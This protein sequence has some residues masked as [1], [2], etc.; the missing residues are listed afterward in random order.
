MSDTTN[1]G[2]IEL[3]A[4]AEGLALVSCPLCDRDF[5]A[6]LESIKNDEA[7]TCPHCKGELTKVNLSRKDMKRAEKIAADWAKKHI[8]DELNKTFKKFN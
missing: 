6:L 5:K 8:S 7:I 1:I 4:D 2:Q 3:V